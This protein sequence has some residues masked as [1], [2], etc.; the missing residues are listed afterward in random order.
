MIRINSLG[1]PARLPRRLR[2]E[3]GVT[4]SWT[5]AIVVTLLLL[6]ALAWTLWNGNRGDAGTPDGGIDTALP[7]SPGNMREPVDDIPFRTVSAPG[8]RPQEADWRGNAATTADAGESDAGTEPA[9]RATRPGTAPLP[10]PRGARSVDTTA[11]AGG[12][13]NDSLEQRRTEEARETARRIAEA[14]VVFRDAV[15]RNPRD[16]DELLRPIPGHVEGAL[17]LGALPDD[18]W[19]RRY[20]Y[21]GSVGGHGHVDVYSL[22]RDGVRGG[23]GSDVDVSLRAR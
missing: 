17:G 13:T 15:G 2:G 8:E 4:D 7:D 23:G 16:L 19:G 14:I 10:P 1:A 3:S 21:T 22:G 5:G 12:R 9:V 6:A 11:S 20:R 18:P